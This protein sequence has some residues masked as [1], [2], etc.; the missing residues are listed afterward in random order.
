MTKSMIFC[1]HANECPNVCPCDA[2]CACRE[3][4]CARLPLP[5]VSEITLDKI[6]PA[7][8]VDN[9][10]SFS[11][12]YMR[13]AFLMSE[14][15]TCK[16]LKVGAAIVSSNYRHVYSV[17]YNGNAKGLPNSCD[18]DE[19]GKCGCIHA[20]A[21]AVIN[22]TVGSHLPKFVYCSHLPCSNC[23][24]MIINLGGVEKVYYYADYRIRDSLA[25]FHAVGIQIQEIA[26]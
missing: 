18:S 4:M 19:P 23:A 8:L 3:G 7:F 9:R 6:S 21:N 25:L 13:M 22:C 10:P 14:R 2:D 20:E 15:S 12:I 26:P 17:G 16:R 11:Q 5:R 1:E 24:K